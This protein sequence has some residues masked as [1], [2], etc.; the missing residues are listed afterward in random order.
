MLKH[1]SRAMLA[2]T[3]KMLVVA[4]AVIVLLYGHTLADDR[5][6]YGGSIGYSMEQNSD[7]NYTVTVD[8]ISG[9]VLGTGPCG[10]GCSSSDIGRSTLST[11]SLIT[12]SDPYRFGNFTSDYFDRKTDRTITQDMSAVVHRTYNETV[13]D[14]SEQG[15]WEQ[16]L[17]HFEFI[18]S[19]KTEKFDINF[20]G[21]SWRH[22]TLPA[23]LYGGSVKWHMQVRVSTKLRSDTGK[24]N[25]SPQTIIKP[26]YRVKLEKVTEIRIPVID[27]DEDLVQCENEYYVEGGI[28]S[29]HPPPN[30]HIHKNCTIYINA[31]VSSNYT[32]DSWIAVPLA[33]RDYTRE[34]IK[35][36]DDTYLPGDIFSLSSSPS[37][38]IVQVL[39]NLAAPEFVKPTLEGNHNFILYR[40]ATWRIGIYAKA[41][42]NTTIDSLTVIGRH[43]ENL[44]MSA[45]RQDTLR[46]QVKYTTVSWKPPNG[47]ST[48]HIACVRAADNTGV[49]STEQR[50]FILHVHDEVFNYT[51]KALKGKPYFADIPAPDHF[52]R[53][54]VQTTCVLALYVNSSS[55]ITR[56]QV[57]ESYVE[58][59]EFSPIEL[60][61]HKGE[62]MYKMDLS[63]EH[64]VH[65]K[66]RICFMASDEN[67]VNSQEMCIRIQIE[68]LDPCLSA[69][70]HNSG[71]CKMNITTG[72]YSCKCIPGFSGKFC[73][74]KF[75]PCDPDPCDSTGT[76]LC[77]GYSSLLC[78]C[79]PGYSGRTCS[80][81]IN[82]CFNDSCNG[83]GVCTDKIN[84]YECGCYERYNGTRCEH[85]KC[86]TQA[87]GIQS[88]SEVVEQEL[89]NPNPC[90]KGNC[91]HHKMQYTCV[92]PIGYT[93]KSCE[94][95][96]TTDPCMQT[97]C[98]RGTCFSR[99][100]EFICVCPPGFTGHLCEKSGQSSEGGHAVTYVQV[101]VGRFFSLKCSSSTSTS[102]TSTEHWTKLNACGGYDVFTATPSPHAIHATLEDSGQYICTST[103]RNGT[104]IRRHFHVNVVS[105][106]Q[107][108]NC[109]FDNGTLCRWRQEHYSDWSLQNGRTGTG[110]DND[111]TLGTGRGKYLHIDSSRPR[112]QGEYAALISPVQPAN[113][114]KCFEFWYYIFGDATVGLS[115][116]LQ[117]TCIR[118]E[119][120]IFIKVGS[121]SDQWNKA[122]V[123][124]PIN[125]IP[126]DY[127]VVVKADVGTTPHGDIAIDDLMLNKGPCENNPGVPIIG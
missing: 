7:G 64:H 24:P 28:I 98:I 33:L 83:H 14:V 2:S 51:A 126:H 87:S 112:A 16:E 30:V 37:Q 89:C 71:E 56:I 15:K 53:C 68:P 54:K 27:P 81:N 77:T 109:N 58:S 21:L 41:V 101:H 17:L 105:D 9:W 103:D 5:Q 78:Y 84:G 22:L 18:L 115:V 97:P 25:R 13:I 86:P 52:V 108:E 4:L 60:V 40:E 106:K 6:F 104:P 92:C 82:D 3:S 46:P 88:C 107:Q 50:C 48:S 55:N 47:D 74:I 80:E 121:Q 100:T 85:D 11:R 123:T 91:F 65:G 26:Y 38:F 32:D 31:S 1:I 90:G 29:T 19:N 99:S 79:K 63:F 102:H 72:G 93:G 59:Y 96:M 110:P 76:L 125:S 43:G 36:G 66:N 118:K 8:L 35:Y 42:E 122:V 49:E 61:T 113:R 69:P 117:D 111:H 62:Q 20:D 124:I 95:E 75:D 44:K 23:Q 39:A 12:E 67:G 114:T 116:L 57:T 127:K 94:L 45:L 73:E 120:Q 10:P 119:T 34:K 70:C